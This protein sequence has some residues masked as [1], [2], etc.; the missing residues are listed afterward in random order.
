MSEDIR[1]PVGQFS[2]D[3]EMTKDLR[4]AFIKTIDDLPS[5]IRTAI[6]GL[7]DEQLDTRYR[8][9]GWTIRQVVHHIADSHMNSYC[10]FRLAMTE[11]FPTIKGYHEDLWAELPD[12]KL[13]VEPSMKIIE[14]VHT[15]WA[16]MLNAMSDEDFARKLNHSESGEWALDKMLGLYDWH[17]KHHTAHITS[18][19]ERKGW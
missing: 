7:N 17:S 19:R 4:T 2:S 13:P 12:N 9:E 11:E 8:S 10:R 1:F 16:A 6:D 18:L 5:A 3:F 14:G 15:R